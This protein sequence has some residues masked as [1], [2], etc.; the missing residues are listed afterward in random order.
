[1]FLRK[2]EELSFATNCIIA[3]T[4][5]AIADRQTS[6]YKNY[7]IGED[8]FLPASVRLPPTLPKNV[9]SLTPN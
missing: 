1:M 8:S 9:A 7:C 2:L 4:I 5:D 3:I 6:I